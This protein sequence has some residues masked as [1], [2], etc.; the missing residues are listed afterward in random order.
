MKIKLLITLC[1]LSSTDHIFAQNDFYS[2]E[3]IQEIEII[4]EEDDWAE[5][6]DG[7]YIAGDKE[8]LLGTVTINGER[9]DSVGIRYKGFSSVSVDRKKNPF[10]IKLDYVS[11]QSYQGI[12][13]I[14]LGNVI[15]DPTFI[16]EALSYEIARNYMP[17]SQA[18]FARVSVNGEF[19]GLYSNVEAVNKDFIADYFNSS[20]NAFFKGAPENLSFTG[21]NANLGN[22][23]G[24]D[25][26]AY[27]PFYDKESDNGWTALVEFIQE[28]N[29]EPDLISNSLNVDRALWMHAFNY[30]VV[31]LDSYI[32]YAQNYYLYQDD[33]GQFN[34]IPWD[35]NMSF[36]SFSITD[37]SDNFDGVSLAA[38]KRLDP[39]AHFNSV[40][41]QPRPLMRNLFENDRY[42]KMYLAH[43]RT[44]LNEQFAQRQ[45]VGRIAEIQSVIRSAVEAD[46][47]KFYETSGFDSNVNTTYTDLI[48]YP[49]ITDLMDERYAYLDNYLGN[50]DMSLAV[51]N[52][53]S[54]AEPGSDLVIEVES[55]SVTTAT[56]YFRENETQRWQELPMTATETDKWTGTLQLPASGVEYYVYGENDEIGIFSPARAAYEFHKVLPSISNQLPFNDV[57]INELM[58]T[59]DFTQADEEGEYDDWIELYNTTAQ[60]LNLAGLYLSDKPGQFDKWAFPDTILP[61]DDYMIVWA[62][63]DGSQG[64]L[65]ANFKLSAGGEHVYLGYADGTVIDSISF[66]EQEKDFTYG[67]LPNAVGPF[68]KLVPTFQSSNE[69]SRV[70]EQESS[71]FFLYPNPVSEILTVESGMDGQATIILYNNLGQRL[72]QQEYSKFCRLNF[73]GY[74]SGIYFVTVLEST[75][76]STFRIIKQ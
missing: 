40:S 51:V 76:Q 39:L 60:N 72:A 20:S 29:E 13:K 12:N 30:V 8:R 66:S 2:L 5:I 17:A 68:G 71:D 25:T 26:T 3:S 47:N 41:V 55:N 54:F 33:L 43:I 22:N 61:A 59:Q 11:N 69:T 42:R 65:H 9:L 73:S 46:P 56:I 48:Q 10:N 15:H 4:F 74:V 19:L 70:E 38:A 24:V 34:T 32:G 57:V 36:G 23:P 63:E 49:G 62:D 75:K 45:Y 14:K 64:P 16:R 52:Q 18:N 31:N 44:I 58:A 1:L 35:L 6:L 21:E 28:L 27:F 67:R 37:A 50:K 7:F 53:A